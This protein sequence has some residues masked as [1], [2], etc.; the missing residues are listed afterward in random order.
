MDF[1]RSH[2]AILNCM[3]EAVYVM[4]RDMD[5]LYANP[6]AEDLTGYTVGESVGKKCEDIFCEASFRCKS[7]CPPKTAMREKRPILHR[8][9]ETKNKNGGLR[10]TQISF[11]PFYWCDECIGSVIVIKDITEV[12]EAEEQREKLIDELQSALVQVKLLSGLLPICSSCKK[13]RDDKGYWNQ[14]EGYIRDHS[15]AEFTHSICPE[16]AKRLYPEFYEKMC[17]AEKKDTSE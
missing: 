6:A 2:E 17:E 3:S 8:E 14:I 7:L 13:I 16:C 1:V 15:E 11:S 12:K 9:A 5:I 10:Q 4:D